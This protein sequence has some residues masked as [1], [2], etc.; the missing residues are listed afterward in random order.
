MAWTAFA[1]AA[2]AGGLSG[3]IVFQSATLSQLAI[4]DTVSGRVTGLGV[5]GHEPALAPD[6]SRLAYRD[7]RDHLHVRALDSGADVAIVS[8][9][10]QYSPTFVGNGRIGYIREGRRSTDICIARVDG[11]GERVWTGRLPVEL[12]PSMQVAWIPGTPEQAPGFV[13][14]SRHGLFVIGPAAPRNLVPEKSDF[15]CRYPAVSPDGKSVAFVEEQGTYNIFAADL[16]SGAV[17]QLTRT[18]DSSW[19]VWSPDGQ[20]IAFLTTAAVTR[21]LEV[22]DRI[23]DESLGR[24]IG[25]SIQKIAVMTA[26]GSGIA[27]ITSGG[28][29]L[30]TGGDQIAWR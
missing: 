18:G 24:T 9:G 12:T 7:S 14:K 19:P 25:G 29:P 1:P 17:T 30:H 21:G 6:G 8:E 11:A 20:H 16:A 27:V 26:H 28:K 2:P 23:T 4:F 3:R 15:T 5:R 13:L 10:S 22:R